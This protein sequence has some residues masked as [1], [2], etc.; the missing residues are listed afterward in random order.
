MAIRM[1][2]C[3]NGRNIAVA[4][5]IPGVIGAFLIGIVSLAYFGQTTF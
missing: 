2:R 5:T 4:W 3:K 1:S